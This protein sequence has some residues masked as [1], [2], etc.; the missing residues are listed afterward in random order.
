M[1][2]TIDKLR[3]RI[4][5]ALGGSVSTKIDQ[6]DILNEA[7]RALVLMKPDGWKF[8]ERPP[9]AIDFVS[10]QQYVSLPTDFGQ[11]IDIGYDADSLNRFSLGTMR[12]I[13]E[14]RASGVIPPAEYVGVIVQGGQSSSTAAMGSARI[15]IAPT[16]PA[17]V[18]GALAVYYRAKWTDLV[19]SSGN[20]VPNIPDHVHLLYS[21]IVAA[22]A[23]GYNE[24]DAGSTTARLEEIASGWLFNSASTYD[25]LIQSDYG[26]LGPGAVGMGSPRDPIVWTNL[27]DPS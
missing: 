8:L 6:D 24:R 4:K 27:A 18:T 1:A 17:S 26:P 22:V 3:N 10:G 7:G 15:E 12:E 25:S 2:L 23:M 9:A 21:E 19:Y 16:P 13:A 11:L 20:E 14:L 5:L